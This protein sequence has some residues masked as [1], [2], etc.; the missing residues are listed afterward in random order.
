MFRKPTGAILC[1][2]CGRLT[3][4]DAV[5]CLVC[6]LQRP[7]RWHW[8]SGLGRLWRTG[9]F[10]GLV[11]VACVALYVLSLLLDP[12]SSLRPRGPFDLFSPSSRA[13]LDLGMTGAI[14]WRNGAWWTLVTAI[15]LHGSLLHI[16]FNVLW[17]RQLGP[18][19]EELYGPARLV[20]VFTV[21]GVLGFVASNALG[22]PFTVGASGS[23]F[24]LL[25]AMVAYG[26]RRGGA[27]GAMVLRQYGQ[28]A[29]VLFV[30]G[31]F[32]S[33]VNN[34]AHTGGFIGGFVAGL[35][36]SLSER[37]EETA[38]ER[39]LATAVIGI[40]ALSFVLALWTAFVG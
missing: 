37:R 20:L 5:E 21:S 28:W 17:I 23:I 13:L 15:Y 36:L 29:L 25:G 30:L 34:L 33:G 26:R 16:L 38:G 40:T 6:G 1:P 22:V 3:H 14:P 9:S 19:V 18:A 31:F 7:G 32:M 8:A 10:T 4:P 24:G 35:V 2:R 12:T 27:F 39:L 11:T